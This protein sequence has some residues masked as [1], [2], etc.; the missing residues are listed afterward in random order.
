[1][2]KPLAMRDAL[3]V[4]E[5]QEVAEIRVDVLLDY[6]RSL[7]DDPQ[8]GGFAVGLAFCVAAFGAAAGHPT[9]LALVG[10]AARE[11]VANSASGVGRF[12]QL[13]SGVKPTGLPATEGALRLRRALRSPYTNRNYFAVWHCGY[14]LTVFEAMVHALAGHGTLATVFIPFS[15]SEFDPLGAIATDP[16]TGRRVEVS[17]GVRTLADYLYAAT[18]YGWSRGVRVEPLVVEDAERDLETVLLDLARM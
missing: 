10:S 9:R 7:L 6:S 16:E 5:Y 12:V 15:T 3:V 17:G 2:L 4:R 14:P 1:M 18:R 13:L 11:A 8:A